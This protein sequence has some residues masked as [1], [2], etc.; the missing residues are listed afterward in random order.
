MVDLTG[1]GKP[2]VLPNTVNVVVWYELVK[3]ADGKGFDM[4]E[5]RLRHAGRRPR[6]RLGRRQ[7]RRPGR[8][9]HAQGLV[10]GPADPTTET[11]AWHPEWNLGATGIQILARDVDGDGLADLVCGMGHDYG[12]SG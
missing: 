12:L 9:A 7:R 4:E 8:P 6:R 11:W 5:A 10:R 1:D 3:K 2:D